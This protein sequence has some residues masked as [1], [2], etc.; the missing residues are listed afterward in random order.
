M[1]YPIETRKLESQ[2]GFDIELAFYYDE[3]TTPHDFECYT[4][5]QIEAYQNDA[6]HYCALKVT[7]KCAGVSLGDAWL[8]GIEIGGLPA[9]TENDE[10]VKTN[11]IWCDEIIESHSEYLQDLIGWA[12]DEAQETLNKIN[13]RLAK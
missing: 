4:Q 7:A 9:T 5:K 10:L 1:N 3:H 13:E 8:G 2:N 11:W 12:T 6:W